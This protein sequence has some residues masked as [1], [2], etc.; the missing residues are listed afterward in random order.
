[1]Q[2]LRSTGLKQIQI[3]D[4][5]LRSERGIR[6]VLSKQRS[7][8]SAL[9]RART[10]RPTKLTQNILDRIDKYGYEHPQ[11]SLY[12]YQQDL[13]LNLSLP[14][15]N[16]ALNILHLDLH[17]PR[18]KPNITDKQQHARKEHCDRRYNWSQVQY[19]ILVSCDEMTIEYN[20]MPAQQHVRYKKGQ[21]LRPGTTR[22][23][24]KSGRTSVNVWGAIRKGARS[25]LV[26]I[27]RRTGKQLQNR[28][29]KKKDAGGLNSQQY[30]ELIING[31]LSNFMVRSPPDCL[32]Q[33]DNFGP[34]I[35]K[36]AL[37]AFEAYNIRLSAHPAASP[38]LACIEPM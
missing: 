22:K 16:K 21:G 3:A 14:T 2:P 18:S 4:Q 1:M 20:P 5:L 25:E 35:T 26:W 19:D 30:T 37:S 33:Q 34:H 8:G 11:A 31:E 13:Q 38:D 6:K 10:G 17:T 27:K 32:L 7:T 9:D 15:I 36:Q 12:N 28:A 29:G 24:F 23:T